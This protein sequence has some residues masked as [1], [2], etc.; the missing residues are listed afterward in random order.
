MVAKLEFT[1]GTQSLSKRI[2][3]AGLFYSADTGWDA[4]INFDFLV[5][6]RLAIWP[7]KRC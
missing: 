3:C 2:Q 7:E 1:L 4:I 6:N 5:D